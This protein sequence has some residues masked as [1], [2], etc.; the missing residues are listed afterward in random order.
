ML[1]ERPTRFMFFQ[2]RTR[3]Q[4]HWNTR[5]DPQSTFASIWSTGMSADFDEVASA[6]LAAYRP[7]VEFMCLTAGPL[8]PFR[9]AVRNP[10]HTGFPRLHELAQYS[11][12]RRLTHCRAH[13]VVQSWLDT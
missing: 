8:L 9:L 1:N 3:A 12:S 5:D 6:L 11:I 4:E 10:A 13:T 7:N 2:Y